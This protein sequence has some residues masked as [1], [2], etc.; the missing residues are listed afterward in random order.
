MLGKMQE[1]HRAVG[2]ILSL[3]YLALSWFE[4]GGRALESTG[5]HRKAKGLWKTGIWNSQ[6]VVKGI[7]DPFLQLAI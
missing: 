6:W 4:M 1:Q 3:P 5:G 7:F 2:H